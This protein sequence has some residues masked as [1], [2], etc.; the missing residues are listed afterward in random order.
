MSKTKHPQPDSV[1]NF[2][3]ITNTEIKC[4]KGKFYLYSYTICNGKKKSG[5]IL[6]RITENGFVISPKRLR[7]NAAIIEEILS[8]LLI[9]KKTFAS[10]KNRMKSEN[11]EAACTV[12]KSEEKIDGD[13]SSESTTIQE[14]EAATTASDKNDLIAENV[15]AACTVEKSEAKIDEDFGSESTTIQETE[16]AT[17]ASDQAAQDSKEQTA[18]NS[19]DDGDASSG[20]TVVKENNVNN[21]ERIS[22]IHEYGLTALFYTMTQEYRK[23]LKE[24]FGSLWILIYILVFIRLFYEPSLKRV[25]RHYTNS[26]ISEIFPKQNM[27]S[28][29]ISKIIN[30]LGTMRLT[31]SN[32]YNSLIEKIGDNDCIFVA[33]CHKLISYSKNRYLLEQG[34]DSKER[35]QD[36][37]SLLVIYCLKNHRQIP[38][39]SKIFSGQT[40]D[41]NTIKATAN[42]CNIPS[43]SLIIADRGMNSNELCDI[44]TEKGVSFILP[45]K[46]NSKV[47]KD[48]IPLSTNSYDNSFL[49]NGRSIFYKEVQDE[50]EGRIIIYLDLSLQ[51]KETTACIYNEEKKKMVDNKEENCNPLKLTGVNKDGLE[52]L[53]INENVISELRKTDTRGIIAFR[54]NDADFSNNT[55][56][57][58]KQI[59]CI[60]KTRP[61]IESFFD[62]FDNTLHFG[63]SNMQDDISNEG[64]NFLNIET[65][66]CAQ[67]IIDKIRE[68]G[69]TKEISFNDIKESFKYLYTCINKNNQWVSN[70]ITRETIKFLKSLNIDEDIFGNF[71][72]LFNEAKRASL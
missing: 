71:L 19:L 33:D 32:Y 44:L 31:I 68:N 56:L 45:L 11:V 59:F 15:E 70:P 54:V 57:N 16:G 8:N 37:V 3:K 36:Q 46:R 10:N 40:P 24:S 52:K 7:E 4:I 5:K 72:N 21:H 55:K 41:I 27:S 61:S 60:Y 63:T 47:V 39:Y 29:N 69:K 17:T 9:D 18:E 67:E 34:Y 49:F 38:V 22:D 23:S 43:E 2:H 20:E 30:K 25:I 64:L 53:T 26:F 6:G 48:H 50:S 12:K 62:T 14:T 65:A 42:E 28:S 51:E 58:A 66:R 1:K 13:F 35:H